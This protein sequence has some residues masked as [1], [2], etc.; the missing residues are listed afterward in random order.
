MLFGA[1]VSI[2]GGINE[3]PKRSCD[4]GGEV[5]QIFSRSPRGGQ[6]PKLVSDIVLDF[7][8]NLEK[9]KQKE[10]YIHTP[11]YINLGSK[12]NRIYHGSISVLREELE[13][14]DMNVKFFLFIFF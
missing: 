1:H 13:R 14:G 2:A 10:F 4:L 7:K 5:F 9:Y 12:N 3:A 6:A 11:Y 8:N